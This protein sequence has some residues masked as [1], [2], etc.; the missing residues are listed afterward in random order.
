MFVF[1]AEDVEWMVELETERTSPLGGKQRD[2]TH[3][4]AIR[5]AVDLLLSQ[6]IQLMVD[7]FHNWREKSV[8]VI[9]DHI[10]YNRFRFTIGKNNSTESSHRE[11]CPWSTNSCLNYSSILILKSDKQHKT[12]SSKRTY[13]CW[14]RWSPSSLSPC[15][16]TL[17]RHLFGPKPVNNYGG[18]SGDKEFRSCFI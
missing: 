6:V 1:I 7:L 15:M 11:S 9:T 12:P 13:R 16:E 5:K 17:L 4:V 3:H 2:R 8:H 18:W 14:E 10:R